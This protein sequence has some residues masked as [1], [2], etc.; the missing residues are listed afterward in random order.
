MSRE[1]DVEAQQSHGSS[2]CSQP[3]GSVTQSQGSSSQSQGISSSSTSTMPN[4]SQSS[5]SSSGTLSSLETVSTQELYS[6]PED[7]EPEDQEP[8]EPTPAPWARLWALQDGFANLDEDMKRKFQ[9]LLSEENESTALPQVLAQPSTSRKRPR[10]GEAEGA[11]T[12]KR[13]AVC[14]AVL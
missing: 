14:A 13:P 6:I 2:A 4:S 8:E 9:D 7:Q 3:H 11:E 1:S 5:H 10:E 12:T